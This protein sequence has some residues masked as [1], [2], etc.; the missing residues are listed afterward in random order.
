[1]YCFHRT[2]PP[3]KSRRE[4]SRDGTLVLTDTIFYDV[5]HPIYLTSVNH[6]I[7]EWH[8]GND[9]LNSRED[10]KLFIIIYNYQMTHII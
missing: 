5:K 1:M 6:E 9:S 7:L 3:K 8:R 10:S 2:E 4:K